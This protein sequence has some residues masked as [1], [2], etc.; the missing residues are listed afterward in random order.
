M[1]ICR[2]QAIAGEGDERNSETLDGRKEFEDLGGFAGSRQGEHKV[3]A[4]DHAEIAVKSFGRMQVE[5]GGSGG[6]EGGGEF[7]A[8]QSALAHAADDD[9]SGAAED[10]FK[11]AGEV[12]S[13][14]AGDAVGEAAQGL[15]FNA[16]YFFTSGH[17][18]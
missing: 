8:D 7:A 9:A 13:H 2:T 5:R 15:G 11:S 6:G 14:G 10:E 1:A 4:H 12:S 17:D 18:V 16:D 3:A